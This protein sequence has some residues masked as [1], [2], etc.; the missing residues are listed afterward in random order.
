MGILNPSSL[1][2]TIDAINEAYFLNKGLTKSERVEAAKWVASRQGERGSYF[3]MFAPTTADMANGLKLF[4]GEVVRSRVGARH[5]LGEEACRALLLLDVPAQAVAAALKTATTNMLA[6]I[7]ENEIKNEVN[8]MYCCGACSVAY[9]R[10]ILAGGLNK[11]EERL[12]A[13]VKSLKSLRKG[14]GKWRRFPFYYTLLA[15]NE[16][17]TK[18]AIE[19]MRYASPI[20]ERSLK[21]SPANGKYSVR[22]RL[23]A[24][25]ILAKC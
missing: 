23:L 8:G 9:W 18:P 17:D 2:E 13:G 12:K 24:E 25:R 3:G 20:L 6:R 16:I 5:I 7:R 14:D 1:S 22:R 19:E 11:Q 21:R 15:L 4:T 10:N